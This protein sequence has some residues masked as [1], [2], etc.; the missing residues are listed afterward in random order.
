[1]FCGGAARLIMVD[2]IF[3]S[4]QNQTAIPEVHQRLNRKQMLT[5]IL[6]LYT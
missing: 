2:R 6:Q 3:F 4:V 1:M 5:S